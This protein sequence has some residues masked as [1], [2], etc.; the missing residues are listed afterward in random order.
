VPQLYL[1]DSGSGE[2]DDGTFEERGIV[3]K[4]R[5]APA[6]LPRVD[7]YLTALDTLH[8]KLQREWRTGLTT[9]RSNFTK[10][11]SKARLPDNADDDLFD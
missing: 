11:N 1:C 8:T 9:L 7:A 4:R 2:A 10:E 6:F 3:I 5:Y